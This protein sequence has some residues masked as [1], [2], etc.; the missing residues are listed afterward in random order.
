MGY[1]VSV[2]YGKLLKF[3]RKF[4]VEKEI[5]KHGLTFKYFYEL[6][7]RL[8]LCRSENFL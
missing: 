8:F 6:P 7:D 4:K 5:D 2:L 3:L 1:N